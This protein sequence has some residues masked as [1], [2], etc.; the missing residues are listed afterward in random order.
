MSI[1]AWL[2]WRSGNTWLAVILGALVWGELLHLLGDVVTPAGVPLWYPI[3]GQRAHIPHPLALIGEPIM[4][5]AA[6]G[7]GAYLL[8]R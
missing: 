4:V 8:V 7:L 1:A 2:A 5:L 6:V 3:S